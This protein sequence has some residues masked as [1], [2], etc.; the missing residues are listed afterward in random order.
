MERLE[1]FF[2]RNVMGREAVSDRDWQ[3]FLEQEVTPR[4]PAGFTVLDSYGQYRNAGGTIAME[5]SKVLIIIAAGNA[6]ESS[7]VSVIR[8]AY[9]RRFNQESVLLVTN[10]ACVSL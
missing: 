4:F 2:G 8:D 10:Q 1:L 5:R 6:D 9:K 3:S 7:R